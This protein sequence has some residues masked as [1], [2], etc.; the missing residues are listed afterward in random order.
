VLVG[1][2]ADMEE[3]WRYYCWMEATQW[4]FLPYAGALEDQEQVLMDNIFL[5]AASV[6]RLRKRA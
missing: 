1:D 2:E 5:I 4:R 3:A 6:N